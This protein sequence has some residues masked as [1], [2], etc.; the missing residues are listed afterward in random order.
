MGAPAKADSVRTSPTVGRLG[1][2]IATNQSF[3]SLATHLHVT[4]FDGFL[5]HNDLPLIVYV[6]GCQPSFLGLRGPPST[7]MNIIRAIKSPT[8]NP[9]TIAKRCRILRVLTGKDTRRLLL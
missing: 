7:K 4:K 3:R 2:L 1:V 5:P 8:M 6:G 9:E